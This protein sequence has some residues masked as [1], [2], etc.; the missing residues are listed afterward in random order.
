MRHLVGFAVCGLT[1]I[2]L[3]GCTVTPHPEATLQEQLLGQ[4]REH[5]IDDLELRLNPSAEPLTL[6]AAV[7]PDWTPRWWD[8]P[9]ALNLAAAPPLKLL[10]AILQPYPHFMAPDLDDKEKSST[11][12]SP[13]ATEATNG[14]G[15]ATMLL[16]SGLSTI[17]EAVEFVCERADWW[18]LATPDGFRVQPVR[19]IAYRLNAQ[20][21]PWT[22]GM[23]VQGLDQST[24][25]SSIS[26][27]T[28][29]YDEIAKL[30]DEIIGDD[31]DGA[32]YL[33][34]PE[35][36]EVVIT[37][38]PSAHARLRP[39]LEH[40]NA[41]HAEVVEVRVAVFEVETDRQRGFSLTPAGSKILTSLF[42]GDEADNTLTA[43]ISD[44]IINQN[45]DLTFTSE[46]PSLAYGLALRLLRSVSDAQVVFKEVLETRNNLIT[47]SENARQQSFLKSL[48]EKTDTQN[49]TGQIT[50]Q[51]EVQFEEITTGWSISVQPTIARDGLITLRVAVQR[52]D[53]VGV[54]PYAF[55]EATGNNF[56]V[57]RLSRALSVTLRD[58][59]SRLVSTLSSLTASEASAYTSASDNATQVEFAILLTA[60]TTTPETS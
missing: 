11:V 42:D 48:A 59:E 19:S 13:A 57:D 9:L 49:T 34:S 46:N 15:A 14:D 30:L 38:S 43:A 6:F 24:G 51:L 44:T 41:R 23:A 54:V 31:E 47:T 5:Q 3:S 37:G 45:L 55:G 28:S 17:G 29:P 40:Y 53:L 12:G 56:I 10:R 27:S 26:F 39:H 21:G 35:T 25:Q 1:V 60:T 32:T 7:E 50:R 52:N 8:E 33:L 4:V 58:G 2:V 20:P 22:G 36:N 16:P 18:C